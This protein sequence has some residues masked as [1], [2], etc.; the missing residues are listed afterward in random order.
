MYLVAHRICSVDSRKP[1]SS[2]RTSL[3]FAGWLGPCRTRKW[4]QSHRPGTVSVF[5]DEPVNCMQSAG[6]SPRPT[7]PW[8]HCL[9]PCRPFWGTGTV[10]KRRTSSPTFYAVYSTARSGLASGS[11]ISARWHME[12]VNCCQTS[13]EPKTT[14]HLFVAAPQTVRTWQRGCG[15][16]TERLKDRQKVWTA[17]TATSS[18]IKIKHCVRYRTVVVSW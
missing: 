11:G 1:L 15:P 7:Q 9:Y 5:T 18:F 17:L 14:P 3:W 4:R 6:S 13:P 8:R 12:S 10:C 2:R 16:Y